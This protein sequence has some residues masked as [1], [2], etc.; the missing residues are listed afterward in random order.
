MTQHRSHSITAHRRKPHVSNTV[1][2]RYHTLWL[3]TSKFLKILLVDSASEDVLLIVA[4]VVVG[5]GRGPVV[6]IAILI[7]GYSGI[8]L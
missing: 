4:I 7:C 6:T 2:I 5:L 1:I 3:H 8:V